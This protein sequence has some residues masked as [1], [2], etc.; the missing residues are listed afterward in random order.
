MYI[1]TE[2]DAEKRLT[3]DSSDLWFLLEIECYVGDQS[4]W[5]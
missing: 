1:T 5:G 4:N 2:Q 3:I